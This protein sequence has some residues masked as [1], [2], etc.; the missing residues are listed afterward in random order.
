MYRMRISREDL[1]LYTHCRNKSQRWRTAGC[2]K[3]YFSRY[4]VKLASLVELELFKKHS[5]A[6]VAVGS[7]NMYGGKCPPASQPPLLR[8][9]RPTC[10]ILVLFSASECHLPRAYN[11]PCTFADIAECRRY[12][13]PS[14]FSSIRVC[15]FCDFRET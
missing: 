15:R 5:A 12:D 13:R 4:Y 1:A 14:H 8:I 10:R 9:R 3:V 7:L 2:N 11:Y 6:V